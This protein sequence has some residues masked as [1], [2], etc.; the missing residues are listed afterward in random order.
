MTTALQRGTERGLGDPM[1]DTFVEEEAKRS[2]SASPI[3][4][5]VQARA[6]VRGPVEDLDRL[7][8]VRDM[9]RVTGEFFADH[10]DLT[11]AE[12]AA[13]IQS[14]EYLCSSERIEVEYHNARHRVAR[15]AADLRKIWAAQGREFTAR[16]L[17][18]EWIRAG[19]VLRRMEETETLARCGKL[20]PDRDDANAQHLRELAGQIADHRSGV[21][22]ASIGDRAGWTT[23]GAPKPRR[24]GVQPDYLPD[25]SDRQIDEMVRREQAMT[26][27][28]ILASFPRVG[29]PV[30]LL[31]WHHY[32]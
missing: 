15:S 27:D 24:P 7:R 3:R 29:S 6:R 14:I 10:D 31:Y 5:L 26:S 13:V 4:V 19:Y 23:A 32:A 21:G 17:S 12:G 9:L 16:D 28:E 22:V 25:P 1:V 11:T 30:E 8:F 20:D 18:E 2:R